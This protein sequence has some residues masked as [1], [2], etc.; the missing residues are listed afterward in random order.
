MTGISPEK[1][2]VRE[3]KNHLMTRICSFFSIKSAHFILYVKNNN[4]TILAQ[5]IPFIMD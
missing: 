3:E 2:R 1:Y 5:L 4:T